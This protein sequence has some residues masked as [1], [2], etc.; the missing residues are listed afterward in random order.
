MTLLGQV[1]EGLRDPR[2][3]MRW[4]ASL[5]LS[6]GG[7]WQVLLLS[8]LIAALANHVGLLMTVDFSITPRD[9]IEE[10]V[11]QNATMMARQPFVHAIVFASM[12][13]ISVFMLYWVSRMCG[14]TGGFGAGILLIAYVNFIHTVLF[15]GQLAIFVLSPP[16][17]SLAGIAVL[18]LTFWVFTS[19]ISELH[20]FR[21]LFRIFVM[22]LMTAFGCLFGLIF[23]LTIV[24]VILP[25]GPV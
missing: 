13:V 14:G 10:L 15:L 8:A 11:L 6:R 22:I 17:A 12:L 9:P 7:Q 2:G 25:G 23:L 5:D 19:A 24:G 18:V 16:L 20:G 1:N 4:L 3:T 21:S